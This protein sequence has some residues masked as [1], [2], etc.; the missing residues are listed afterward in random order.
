[1]RIEEGIK[2]DFKDVLI[3]PKRS[4]LRSRA[5]VDLVREFTFLHTKKTW[6]GVPIIAANMD[7]TGTF[8]MASALAEHSM[9]T[10]IHK[11]YTVDEWKDFAGSHPN[12]LNHVAVS[13]GTTAN[14]LEKLNAVLRDIP[15][16]PFICLDVA[17]G[18]SENFVQFVRRSPD[19]LARPGRLL[20]MARTD[21][22]RS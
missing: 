1:M 8:A 16:I 19:S 3:R 12:V 14:D 11:H 2:L 4:T 7:T 10:C 21:S 20:T 17:N 6:A 18:Y 5:D 9:L 13:S 22:T 15:A